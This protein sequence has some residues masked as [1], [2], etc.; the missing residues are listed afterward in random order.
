[1]RGR[2]GNQNRTPRCRDRAAERVIIMP[3]KPRAP[4]KWVLEQQRR[5]AAERRAI[6]AGQSL[7]CRR[8]AYLIKKTIKALRVAALICLFVIGMI[9]GVFVVIYLA[10]L[11]STGRRRR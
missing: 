2:A 6:R 7:A 1:M 4:A 5:E 9:G 3:Y 10:L 8:R 11:G